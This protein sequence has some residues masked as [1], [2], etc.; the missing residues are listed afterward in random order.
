MSAHG[1]FSIRMTPH[2]PQEASSPDIG[3]L[4]FDKDWAGDLEGRSQGEMLSFGNPAGGTASYVVLEVFTGS[5]HGRA[6]AF[7]FRQVGDMHAG[8]V[9][10]T[11]EV[12][13]H[14]GS[15]DLRGLGGTLTL[16]REGGAHVYVL[17]HTL[18]EATP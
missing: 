4:H 16:T 8:E 18:P 10:L 11:Y 7:A 13:P 6:G 2:A 15:G 3:R 1:T 5:L 9:T 14:S 12:V 17:D